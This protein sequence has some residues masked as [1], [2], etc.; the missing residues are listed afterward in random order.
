VFDEI[1]LRP[2]GAVAGGRDEWI[3]DGWYGV[4]SVIRLDPGQFGTG[5]VLGLADFSHLE[6]VFR[7]DRIDPS[8]VRTEPRPPR[9]DPAWPAV[10]VFAGH[11]PFRPNLLGVSRC[12]LPA[13]EGL[14]LHVA[15]LDALD[16]T[17]GAG[18]QALPGRVRAPGP[19]LAAGLVGRA[20]A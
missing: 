12:R 17:P 5:V 13:V 15:D 1:A 2:I 7:F 8:A 18:R 11:G 3:E 16:G 14:D 10:G 20:H 6:V 4:K 19:G 9:G